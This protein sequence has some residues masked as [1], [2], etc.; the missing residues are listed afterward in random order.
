MFS[1]HAVFLLSHSASCVFILVFF[2]IGSH[3]LFA[4]LIFASQVARIIDMSPWACGEF[5]FEFVK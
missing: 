4:S 3:T 2:K 5:E 1:R